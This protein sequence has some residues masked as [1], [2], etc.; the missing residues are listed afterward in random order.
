MKKVID[1][2]VWEQRVCLQTN[3]NLAAAQ[4]SDNTDVTTE[5]I[6]GA[7]TRPVL[8]IITT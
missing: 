8:N 3:T 1:D 7:L 5:K 4:E 2:W 6:C